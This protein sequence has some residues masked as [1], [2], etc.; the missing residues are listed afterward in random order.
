MP[1]TSVNGVG[2][3]DGASACECTFLS[4]LQKGSRRESHHLA[5]QRARAVK[6]QLGAKEA[7]PKMLIGTRAHKQS[8]QSADIPTNR[9]LQDC[10]LCIESELRLA[11]EVNVHIVCE[12]A[13]KA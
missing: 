8:A 4:C 12:D 1:W 3:R 9:I 5:G 11:E 10:L 2:N 7:V 13:C 6:K